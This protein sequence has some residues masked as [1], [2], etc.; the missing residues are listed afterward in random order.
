[1]RRQ[2]RHRCEPE[3]KE[4]HKLIFELE[5]IAWAQLGG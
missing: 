4:E 5:R 3:R 1:M 2:W